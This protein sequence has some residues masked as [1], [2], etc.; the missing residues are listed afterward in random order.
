MASS[1][2]GKTECGN[3]FFGYVATSSPGP[4]LMVQP[5]VEMA[6]R[7]SKTRI[8]PLIE[9]SPA[10]RAVIREARSRDSGNSLLA[11]EFSN[12]GILVM[13]GANS[14]SGLRSMPVRFLHL[15]ECDAFPGD[16]D[17][18]G[19][20]CMLAE[21]RTRTFS[22]RKIFYSSTPTIAGRSRIEREYLRSTMNVYKVPCPHCGA[23]QQLIW[24]QV[25]WPDGEPEL[26]RYKCEHCEEEFE[27]HHKNRIL[28]RG[29]WEPQNPDEGEW[30]GYHISTLYAPLGWYSWADMAKQYVAAE[31]SDEAMKVFQNTCLGLSYADTGEAPDWEL[32]HNRREDY[33]LGEVP[34]GAVFITAGVD[35]QKNR[36]ECELVAWGRNLESWSL[37]YVVISGDTTEDRVWE[38]LTKLSRNTYKTPNGLRMPIR[39]LAIDTG[40]RTQ[41][42]YR[43]VR[44]QSA[45]RTM[46]I[47]GREN[48]STILG[49]PSPV[50][51]TVRGKKIRSGI[52][53]WGVGTSVAKSELYG[54]LRRKVPTNME[55]GYP[56]GWCH[57]PMY[58]EEFF[59]Q[60]TAESLVSRIVRGYQK[61]QW[62]KQRE[63]NEALDCRVYAR[64]AAEAL[65]AARWDEKRWAMEA[66]QAGMAAHSVQNDNKQGEK[67]VKRRRS[68]FL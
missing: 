50:D 38:E 49:Q 57:F 22:R 56:F 32:L 44:S 17:G 68:S 46:A 11:K 16:V 36:F 53:V 8:Q 33:P 18:E 61:F 14:A 37:D 20:P 13:A 35:V 48:L 9:E 21:A 67:R 39:M 15:D 24:Q 26:A 6:K 30:A 25:V 65:G 59:K 52:K 47:K 62:E 28:E 54:W 40:Y 43:W 10:L 31:K 3:N 45:Y 19:D 55:D 60:L 42:V 23:F 51:M 29:I 58:S 34:E 4:M 12:G 63:R 27:E 5:T 41:D 66:E 64:A 2:V 1:Q 7:N